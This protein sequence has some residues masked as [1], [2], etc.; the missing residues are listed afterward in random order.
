M[1]TVK[2]SSVLC[3]HKLFKLYESF[4]NLYCTKINHLKTPLV[5]NLKPFKILVT[6]IT[7]QTKSNIIYLNKN[8]KNY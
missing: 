3:D 6:L 7:L 8:F 4:S 1:K 2:T 5:I